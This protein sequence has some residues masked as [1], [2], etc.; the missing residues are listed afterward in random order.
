VGV[1][2]RRQLQHE[3]SPAREEAA[4]VFFEASFSIRGERDGDR[5]SLM[6]VGATVCF[7]RIELTSHGPPAQG[8]AADVAV[9]PLHTRH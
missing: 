9:L 1:D 2:G 7:S 3:R 8:L 4:E 5:V 6:I